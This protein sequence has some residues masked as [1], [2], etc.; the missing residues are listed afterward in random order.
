M[1]GVFCFPEL[2]ILQTGSGG[3]IGLLP[4]L[5]IGGAIA[6]AVVAI[7]KSRRRRETIGEG[8]GVVDE[9]TALMKRYRDAYL[10]ARATA[11]IGKVIKGIG[12]L[13]IAM[14]L[15]NAG[16]SASAIGL[17]VALVGALL[18]CAG[19]LVAAQGQ[20]LLASLDTAVN[21]SPFLTNEEK[22]KAMSL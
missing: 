15:I 17:F 3:V 21:S 16:Q 6:W 10:V 19:V 2:L 5:V 4:I 14:G 18:Y 13:V 1:M 8:D 12:I 9:A 7:L 20:I 22:A 11:T